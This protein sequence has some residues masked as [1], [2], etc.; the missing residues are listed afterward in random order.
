M[1]SYFIIFT[2]QVTRSGELKSEQLKKAY[3]TILKNET[4]NLKVI[5]ISPTKE[6]Q[7]GV[8]KGEGLGDIRFI[9]LCP[10]ENNWTLQES[11]DLN[12][13]EEKLAVTSK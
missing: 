13:N 5:F 7:Q 10:S 1:C 4:K 11:D 9:T 2:N 3:K 8:K 6:S 12:A